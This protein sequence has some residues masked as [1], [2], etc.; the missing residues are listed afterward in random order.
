MF[1]TSVTDAEN[2]NATVFLH[3]KSS[4]RIVKKSYSKARSKPHAD[5]K[6]LECIS[7][8]VAPLIRKGQL[9]SYIY[10][11]HSEEI[12]VSTCTLY[13]SGLQKVNNFGL[14]WNVSYK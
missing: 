5:A 1:A 2:E 10:A 12:G 7:T 14:C 13:Q 11:E 6:K 3:S 4:V 8:F 9:L